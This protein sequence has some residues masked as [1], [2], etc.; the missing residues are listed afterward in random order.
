MLF[1]L[2]EKVGATVE[3]GVSMRLIINQKPVLPETATA[4]ATCLSVPVQ[5]FQ[6]LFQL[7]W[8]LTTLLLIEFI[9]PTNICFPKSLQGI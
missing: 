5:E 2:G 9:I 1:V 3:S 8:K 7:L 6:L 4:A